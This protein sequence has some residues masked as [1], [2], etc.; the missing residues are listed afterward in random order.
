MQ[1][2]ACFVILY[3]STE[4]RK[5]RASG[6]QRWQ[7]ITWLIKSNFAKLITISGTKRQVWDLKLGFNNDRWLLKR[8]RVKWFLGVLAKIPHLFSLFSCKKRHRVERETQV[9]PKKSERKDRKG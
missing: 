6:F 2:A 4:K 7:I 5:I 1:L 8:R 9:D 3:L